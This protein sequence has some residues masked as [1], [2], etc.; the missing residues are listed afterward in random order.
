MRSWCAKHKERSLWR[1]SPSIPRSEHKSKQGHRRRRRQFL[2]E[3]MVGG[4]D[5]YSDILSAELIVNWSKNFN[6]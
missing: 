2:F 3:I 4:N 1:G 6:I 5:L